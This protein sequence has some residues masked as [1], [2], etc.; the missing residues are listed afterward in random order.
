M[1]RALQVLCVAN[2]APSLDALRRAAVGQEW[3]VAGATGGD[4]A[5]KALDATRPHVLVAWGALADLVKQARRRFPGLR[6]V[7]VGRTAVPEADV[8]I[9]SIKD[10]RSA[11]LGVPPVGGPVR[12]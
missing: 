7:A 12:S 6:I 5:L 2:G 1:C 4:E 11:I 9:T 10:V 8:N 3:E